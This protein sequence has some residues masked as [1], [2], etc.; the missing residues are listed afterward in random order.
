VIDDAAIV[1]N[2]EGSYFPSNYVDTFY[3]SLRESGRKTLAKAQALAKASGIELTPML[4]EARGGTV[5]QAIVQQARRAKAD[6]IVLGTHG[7]R[8]LQRVLM[9]SDAE[10]VVR[11]AGVPVMLVRSTERPKR[12]AR[13]STKRAGTRAPRSSAVVAPAARAAG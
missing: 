9:G 1:L 11:E 6:V 10:A 5:A 3:E 7:R 2:F 4:V 8:G 12:G 13:K